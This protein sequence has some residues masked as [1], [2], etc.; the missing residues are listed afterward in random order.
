MSNKRVLIVEDAADLRFLLRQ[1]FEIEGFHVTPAANGQEALA[2]LQAAT[3]LP[4]LILLDLMMPVM[5]GFEFCRAQAADPRLAGI[6]VIVMTADGDVGNKQRRAGATDSLRKP[7][8]VDQLLE[9]VN[10]HL[11]RTPLQHGAR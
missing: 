1:L 5:N 2:L 8:E 9:V 6:P 3:E 4:Q 7:I 10:R 11:R